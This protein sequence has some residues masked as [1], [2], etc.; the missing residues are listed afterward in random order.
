MILW[1]SFSV[2]FSLTSRGLTLSGVSFFS[3]LR[4]FHLMPLFME[5]NITQL[6]YESDEKL[7]KTVDWISRIRRVVE[8]FN[9]CLD[10]CIE[11]E[12]NEARISIVE[13]FGKSSSRY[14]I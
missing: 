8:L 1:D 4:L 13:A 11:Q 14:W 6:S 5:A 9:R 7:R 12:I 10:E 2:P 3:L